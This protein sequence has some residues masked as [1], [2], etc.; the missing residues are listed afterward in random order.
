M[1]SPASGGETMRASKS[2]FPLSSVAAGASRLSARGQRTD[3]NRHA[4][5][6]EAR[7]H[8]HRR[9]MIAEGTGLVWRTLAAT[10]LQRAGSAVAV[11]WVASSA[12]LG[13]FF[14]LF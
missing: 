1:F 11:G 4:L 3:K 2:G 12:P 8:R 10:A 5:L 13:G 9:D 14:F 7:F 6:T